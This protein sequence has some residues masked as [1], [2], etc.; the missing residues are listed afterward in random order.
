MPKYKSE[1]EKNGRLKPE[2]SVIEHR[3]IVDS[4]DRFRYSTS[5]ISPLKY[6]KNY[7]CIEY[8]NASKP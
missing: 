8:T 2:M 5:I 1:I 6:Y 7:F 3:D 4:R